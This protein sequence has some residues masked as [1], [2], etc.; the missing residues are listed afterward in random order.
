MSTLRQPH[1]RGRTQPKNH[2]LLQNLPTKLG[3]VPTWRFSP[4]VPVI[5]PEISG[6]PA[7]RRRPLNH[8]STAPASERGPAPSQPPPPPSGGLLLPWLLTSGHVCR[9]Y[10]VNLDLSEQ[11]GLCQSGSPLGGG[12]GKLSCSKVSAQPRE[13]R[14]LQGNCLCKARRDGRDKRGND[15]VNQNKGTGRKP[16]SQLNPPTTTDPHRE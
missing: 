5:A 6:I 16:P 13:S 9:R 12:D 4:R 1:L 14:C 7:L 2:I 8:L 10:L 15:G 3:R 11:P